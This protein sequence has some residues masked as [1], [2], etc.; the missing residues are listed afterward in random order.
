MAPF[1]PRTL[2]PLITA[3]QPQ[4][5]AQLKSLVEI[6]SP[7]EDPAAINTASALVEKWARTLGARPKYHRQKAYGHVLELRFGPARSTRKPILILGHLDTVW[8]IGTL[9]NMPWKASA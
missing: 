4:L 1:D 7:S 2:F 5:I 3:A 6:E 9:A 8:P